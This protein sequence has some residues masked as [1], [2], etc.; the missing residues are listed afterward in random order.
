MLYALPVNG[1][2]LG[3]VLE[4]LLKRLVCVLLVLPVARGVHR[5]ERGTALLLRTLLRL[6]GGFTRRTRLAS[7]RSAS[8]HN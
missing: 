4:R 7:A 8:T 6:L 3:N 2:S 5:G 1:L